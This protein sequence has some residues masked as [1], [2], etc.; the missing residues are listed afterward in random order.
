[1]P[2]T[3]AEVWAAVNTFF[4]T[5]LSSA[6]G[7]LEAIPIL[8]APLVVWISSKVLGQGKGLFKLG[9]RRR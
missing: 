5:A 9:G 4:S 6:L 8:C 7:T 1:M 2:E 3:I